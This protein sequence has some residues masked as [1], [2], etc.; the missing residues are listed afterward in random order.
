MFY[1]NS[2]IV[3]KNRVHN[4][5]YRILTSL[6][7]AG[8]SD[9]DIELNIDKIDFISH[10]INAQIRNDIRNEIIK[11]IRRLRGADNS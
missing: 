6:K 8:I 1:E 5:A 7:E 9:Q 4:I 11:I 2:R 10:K 3:S